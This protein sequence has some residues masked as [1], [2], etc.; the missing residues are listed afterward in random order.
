MLHTFRGPFP[1]DVSAY[2]HPTI[3]ITNCQLRGNQIYV[4]YIDMEKISRRVLRHVPQ[5]I[6][7]LQRDSIAESKLFPGNR[8][9]IRSQ[10]PNYVC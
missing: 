10:V 2:N 3:C 8:Y 9:A 4:R 5:R 1:I 7:I 6:D